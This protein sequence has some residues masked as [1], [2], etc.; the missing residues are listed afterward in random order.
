LN[1]N[2]ATYQG[3][4]VLTSDQ[5]VFLSGYADHYNHVE[6]TLY[7]DMQRTGKKAASFKNEY[8]VRFSITARQFNAIARNLEGK[9]ASVI[10]L[11][12]LQKQDLQRRI[13]KAEKVIPKIKGE[14]KQHQK[15]RRLH[16]LETRLASVELQIAGKEPRI[17]F[18]GRRLFKKQFDLEA[19]GYQSHEEWKQDWISK[20]NSQFYVLGSRDETAG[21]QGCVISANMDGTFN[22]R[23]R[24][25]SK[26]A[27]YILIENAAIPYGQMSSGAP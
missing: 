20:R 8:L 2:I 24:S 7:A 23:L 22:L 21:C 13:A 26:K 11:L 19:N 6:R 18:G 9:I 17:C 5:E 1:E 4:L 14:E 12:P 16:N 3:R 15:K 27:G 25:L 10:G